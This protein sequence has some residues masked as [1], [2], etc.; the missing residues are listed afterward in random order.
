MRRYVDLS[1]GPAERRGGT[2]MVRGSGLTTPRTPKK[3]V[4]FG[5]LG[6]W[7][8]GFGFGHVAGLLLLSQGAG[9]PSCKNVALIHFSTDVL[10][11]RRLA[12]CR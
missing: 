5:R 11:N 4:L 10:V 12:C 3:K 9:F 7:A 1:A 2:R 6:F 8:L